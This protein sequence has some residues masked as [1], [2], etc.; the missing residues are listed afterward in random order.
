MPTAYAPS[1]GLRRL[2][3]VGANSVLVL[4]VF[5]VAWS[6][7]SIEQAFD[8]ASH[9]SMLSAAM[10][11]SGGLLAG[12]IVESSV[13]RI[14]PLLHGYSFGAW[15]R[16]V[17]YWL[18]RRQYWR[19]QK[20]IGALDRLEDT[21]LASSAAARLLSQF[22]PREQILPTRLGNVLRAAE[23][24]VNERYSLDLAIVYPRLRAVLP[25][26]LNNGLD[27]AAANM[28]VA[29]RLSVTAYFF[30]IAGLL[31]AAIQTYMLLLA[32]T[33]I[34]LAG[35]WYSIAVDRAGYFGTQLEVAFDLHRIPLLQ[36]LNM[37]VPQSWEEERRAF[38]RV[39]GF[40]AGID[41]HHLPFV[42]ST[43]DQSL[44]RLTIVGNPSFG[45]SYFVDQAMAVGRNATARAR[46]ANFMQ[47][48]K[49][50]NVD[51]GQLARE[52]SKLRE[53]LK[54]EPDSAMRDSAIGALAD[55]EVAAESNDRESVFRS[56]TRL[57]KKVVD[58]A[59]G[60]GVGVATAAIK[61]ALGLP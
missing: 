29:A 15:G 44:R 40:L 21:P 45:D 14:L 57:G 23:Y 12:L 47:F 51:L 41:D 3:T 58:I 48:A 42:Y 39:T 49:D 52:L 19:Y 43:S 20:L 30:A 17:V 11:A 33:G 60:I 31:L 50:E 22:P 7:Y 26:N 5:T 25:D 1:L 61:S 10:V 8:Y 13:T 36:R 32:P 28:E 4:F 16:T 34:L 53:A 55:A 35:L 18:M 27:H 37:P 2:I 59:E 46:Q 9:T 38:E 54:D 56:L 6:G 24:R